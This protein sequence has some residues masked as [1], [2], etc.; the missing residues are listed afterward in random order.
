MIG[1]GMKRIYLQKCYWIDSQEN[2]QDIRKNI[3]MAFNQNPHTVILMDKTDILADQFPVSNSSNDKLIN[4]F[5]YAFYHNKAYTLPQNLTLSCQDNPLPE[6]FCSFRSEHYIPNEYQQQ[7]WDSSIS[8]AELLFLIEDKQTEDTIQFKQKYYLEPAEKA[9]NTLWFHLASWLHKKNRINLLS[10]FDV[11]PL[12]QDS[13][14]SLSQKI[15]RHLEYAETCRKWRE[16]YKD[17]QA[18]SRL[19]NH[20][21]ENCN[22]NTKL[23]VFKQT[24]MSALMD[25]HSDKIINKTKELLEKDHSVFILVNS[26]LKDLVADKLKG[27]EKYM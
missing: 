18:I 2:V 23:L 26:A 7:V 13:L 24:L 3:E 15:D 19:L 1:Q 17:Y 16:K 12:Y 27:L 22:E 8:A 11:P 25:Y 6:T 4:Q 20:Y 14:E 21:Y 5:L 10:C 9:I